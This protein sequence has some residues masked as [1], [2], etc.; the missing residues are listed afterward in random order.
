MTSPLKHK[1]KEPDLVKSSIS[2]MV[3]EK[4]GQKNTG[5]EM[6]IE[7]PGYKVGPYYYLRL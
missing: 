3:L 1:E 6:E 7:R 4:H 2:E 5:L